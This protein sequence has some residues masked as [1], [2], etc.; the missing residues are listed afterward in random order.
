M[1]NHLYLPVLPVLTRV[2]AEFRAGAAAQR[3][4]AFPPVRT[5]FEVRTSSTAVISHGGYGSMKLIMGS[6]HCRC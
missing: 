1:A 4:S 3:R 5:I 6:T 2:P